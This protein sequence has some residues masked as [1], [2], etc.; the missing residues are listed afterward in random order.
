[1]MMTKPTMALAMTTK[2]VVALMMTMILP[3]L[4]DHSNYDT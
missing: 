4:E 3:D 1:M 2:L